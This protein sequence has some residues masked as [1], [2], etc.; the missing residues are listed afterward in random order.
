ME[1]KESR[2]IPSNAR[3]LLRPS[4]SFSFTDGQPRVGKAGVVADERICTSRSL[5]SCSYVADVCDDVSRGEL[6]GL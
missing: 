5:S 2:M 4:R 3:Q 6:Y 1:V